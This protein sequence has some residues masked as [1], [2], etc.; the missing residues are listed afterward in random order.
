MKIIIFLNIDT[1]KAICQ[2]PYFCPYF[3]PLTLLP[4][5]DPGDLHMAT[6]IEDT[7]KNDYILLLLN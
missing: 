6:Y 4:L 5:C 1:Y 3:L 7:E 2:Y